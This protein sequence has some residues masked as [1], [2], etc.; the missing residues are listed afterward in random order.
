M[1]AYVILSLAAVSAVSLALAQAQQPAAGG[2][3]PRRLVSPEVQ[4]D[5]KITFRIAAPK[6]AEVQLRFSEGGPQTHPMTKG[7]DGVWSVT[8]GPV[9]PETYTYS[10]L[11]DGLK[12]LDMTNPDI[13]LGLAIDASVVEVPG[14][15]PRFDQLQNVPHGSVNI[16]SY[17]ST[18]QDRQRAM[19]IYV[20]PQY[21]TEP[22]RKFPV[23]YLWHGG[24]GV[25]SD[26]S[27]DGRAAII[28]DNLIAEKKALPMIIVMP[29]NNVLVRDQGG[30]FG[31]SSVLEKEVMN[32][33]IPFVEK[34]YRV[35][36][37]RNNR[38][39]AGLSAGGGTTMNVGMRRL[40]MFAYLGEFS[41]GLFGGTGP[42]P[43]AAAP[44]GGG[45]GYGVYDP[46]KVA[47]GMF[48][49]LV[50]PAKKLKLFWMSV[51]TEDPR[52]PFQ[53]KA[54]AEFQ[55]HGIQP[56]F[57]T[58]PGAHEWKVWRHSLAEFAPLLF[59]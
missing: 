19:Y 52:V 48:Q 15:P 46:E 57:K 53:K 51:G 56:I 25:E 16:H 21:Y 4:P 30:A 36:T 40:D 35:L 2:A 13:K 1:R 26:W 8:I 31:S 9:E 37:G 47:P 7:D 22:S 28:L 54:L 43:G 27:R 11:V 55:S 41:T 49:N 23:F 14:A 58:Y 42:A 38:A 12:V 20:P 32:D 24:G 33:I 18:A 29:N 3:P 45:T 10:F 44:A 39:I 34:H 59:K 6:A 5:R 50:S 17:L